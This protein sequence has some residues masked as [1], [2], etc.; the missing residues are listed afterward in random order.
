VIKSRRPRLKPCPK[1]WD[2]RRT[3]TRKM[4]RNKRI[5]AFFFGYP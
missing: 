2:P 5:D 4:N 1:K 3:R